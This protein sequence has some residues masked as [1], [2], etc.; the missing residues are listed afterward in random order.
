[1]G[2]LVVSGDPLVDEV[3]KLV[4]EMGLQQIIGAALVDSKVLKVLLQDPLSLAD[5]FGLTLAERRFVAHCRPRDLEH[6]ATLVEGW[7]VGRPP[8]RWVEAP[9]VARNQR[10]G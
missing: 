4:C 10:V 1:M 6:F 5:R 8:M 3:R 2:F 9:V 7:A